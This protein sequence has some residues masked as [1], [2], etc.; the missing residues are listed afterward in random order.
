MAQTRSASS[1]LLLLFA[2]LLCLIN[3]V[4]WTF[5]SDMPMAGVAWVVAAGLSVFLQKWSAG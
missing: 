4:V 3:A 2:V 1:V 5:V